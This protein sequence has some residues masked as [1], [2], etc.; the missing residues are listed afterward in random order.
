MEFFSR[1]GKIGVSGSINHRVRIYSSNTLTGSLFIA[2]NFSAQTNLFMTIKRTFTI[3]GGNLIGLPNN[4][5]L[6]SDLL[7]NTNAPQ[8]IAFDPTIDN[9]IFITGQMSSSADTMYHLGTKI[10]N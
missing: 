3:S 7:N 1:V 4:L 10:T 6:S 9:Y 5:N 8:L 2:V